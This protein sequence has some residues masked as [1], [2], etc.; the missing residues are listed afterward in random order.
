MKLLFLLSFL[1][2][3]SLALHNAENEATTEN[4]GSQDIDIL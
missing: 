2:V 3:L 4:E 1:L